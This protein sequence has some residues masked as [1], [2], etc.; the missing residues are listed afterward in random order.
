MVRNVW[1]RDFELLRGAENGTTK[2][3]EMIRR[4]EA[5]FFSDFNL[6]NF[7]SSTFPEL[8]KDVQKEL[9]ALIKNN[10]P[11]AQVP[12]KFPIFRKYAQEVGYL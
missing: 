11:Y 3:I 5:G 4:W 1:N 8:P 10:W 12:E 2:Q 6:W 7:F 9:I